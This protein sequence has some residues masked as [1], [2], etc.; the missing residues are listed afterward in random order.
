MTGNT[1]AAAAAHDDLVIEEFGRNTTAYQAPLMTHI[2]SV[3]VLPA[4]ADA[5]SYNA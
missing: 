3:T 1:F 5:A 2:C 4:A